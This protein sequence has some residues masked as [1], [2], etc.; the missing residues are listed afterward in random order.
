MMDALSRFVFA[1]V[2]TLSSAPLALAE[3]AHQ[4]T[5]AA[6]GGNSHGASTPDSG[7]VTGQTVDGEIRKVDKDAGKITIRHGELKHLNMPAMTMVFRVKDT[8][9]LDQVKAGDKV[10]FVSDKVGGLFTLMQIEVKNQPQSGSA[11]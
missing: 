7:G 6:P 3:D 4:G 5:H 2:I 8:A 9:M 11:H 10:S 1:T